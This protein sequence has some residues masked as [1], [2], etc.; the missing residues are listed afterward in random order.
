LAV[1]KFPSIGKWF[2]RRISTSWAER[3]GLSHSATTPQSVLQMT[4]RQFV[5]DDLLITFTTS[6]P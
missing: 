6:T 2:Q 1:T 5:V 4:P 3:G